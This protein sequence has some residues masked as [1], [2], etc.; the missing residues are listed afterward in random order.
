MVLLALVAP[1]R[2]L[3]KLDT[4]CM[5]ETSTETTFTI[6]GTLKTTWP[7]KQ[8]APIEIRLI[9]ICL[10]LS[11]IRLR[12]SLIRLWFRT[13][14]SNLHQTLHHENAIAT[15]RPMPAEQL[16]ETT[17]ACHQLYCG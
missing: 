7:G 9:L 2:T 1:Q 3:S 5:Q 16:H 14:P 15:Q 6:Q 17:Q 10:R 12:L 13:L 8:L 4:S 11:L